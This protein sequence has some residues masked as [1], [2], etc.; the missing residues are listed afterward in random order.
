MAERAAR[1]CADGARPSSA[2]GRP[3]RSQTLVAQAARRRSAAHALLEV[4]PRAAAP[5]S[6][7]CARGA[8][9]RVERVGQLAPRP[10]PRRRA[11]GHDRRALRRAAASRTSQDSSRS[12]HQ[13]VGAGQV[14]LVHHETSATSSSP[15]FIAWMPSPAPGRS[16]TTVSAERDDVVLALADADGLDQERV[17]AGERRS[18]RT[19]RPSR[20]RGR[21]GCRASPSSG[22]RRP[23]RACA[24]PC[25]CGRRAARRR[26]N[27]LEGSTA[28]MPTRA[29][30][31]RA[32]AARARSTSVLLP[33]PG[34]PVMPMRRARPTRGR[35]RR[36]APGEARV[37][38]LGPGDQA[39][40]G[41]A[42]SPAST[43]A[44]EVRAGGRSRCG[45]SL[46]PAGCARSRCAGCRSRPRRSR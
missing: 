4:A 19:R 14:G 18:R 40:A 22:C 37:A 43:R 38:V 46:R 45:I 36:A 34:G 10:A 1:P 7:A 6:A 23:G 3:R 42:R 31:A 35:S 11:A 33:A 20:A 16:T 21:R 29:A 28:R 32:S 17:E 2:P 13:A 30:A 44:D 8:R 24:P 27:G 25:G 41:A 5:A 15:A 12:L 26:V 9:V 39:R